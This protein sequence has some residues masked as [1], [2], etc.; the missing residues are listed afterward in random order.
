MAMNTGEARDDTTESN[1]DAAQS[2][3]D[4][5]EQASEADRGLH[6]GGY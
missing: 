2:L 6:R 1:A 4:C 5:A 3:E